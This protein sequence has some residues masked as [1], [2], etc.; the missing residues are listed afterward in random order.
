MEILGGLACDHVSLRDIS[1]AALVA[2]TTSTLTF[3]LFRKTSKRGIPYLN[4]IPFLG[5]VS[6]VFTNLVSF[7]LGTEKEYGDKFYCRVLKQEFLFLLNQDDVKYVLNLPMKT[8]NNLEPLFDLF[9]FLMPQDGNLAHLEP[10]LRKLL[11]RN[12]FGNTPHIKVS[13]RFG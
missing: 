1:T 3:F 6:Q 10:E 4:G 13:T 11:S 12:E 2:V 7:V 8:V 9:G 5:C